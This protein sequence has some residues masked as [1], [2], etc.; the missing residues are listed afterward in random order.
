MARHEFL[1][2][3]VDL[4]LVQGIKIARR[5]RYG[6]VLVQERRLARI[7][8]IHIGS[9]TARINDALD[10]SRLGSSKEIA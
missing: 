3:A 9:G 10:T 8:R 7:S 5:S 6:S 2:H 4:G 1:R